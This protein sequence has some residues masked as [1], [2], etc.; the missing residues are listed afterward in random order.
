MSSSYLTGRTMQWWVTWRQRWGWVFLTSVLDFLHLPPASLFALWKGLLRRKAP[1]C[2]CFWNQIPCCTESG[3]IDWF[4]SLFLAIYCLCACF[5]SISNGKAWLTS[6]LFSKHVFVVGLCEANL[7]LSYLRTC[8]RLLLCRW[9]FI[10]H[11]LSSLFPSFQAYLCSMF[12]AF[13][14]VYISL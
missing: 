13:L 6:N 10:P 5:G 3:L 1:Q 7:L 12:G 9:L 2:R 4:L 11:C 8:L 14:W